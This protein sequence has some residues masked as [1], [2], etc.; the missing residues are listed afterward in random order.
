MFILVQVDRWAIYRGCRLLFRE[1]VRLRPPRQSNFAWAPTRALHLQRSLRFYRYLHSMDALIRPWHRHLK[2]TQH[3][4][5]MLN[6][7]LTGVMP[8]AAGDDCASCPPTLLVTPW[9]GG[10]GVGLVVEALAQELCGLGATCVVLKPVP[11]GWLPRLHRGSRG[12]LIVSICMRPISTTQSRARRGAAWMRGLMA[13]LIVV[14][15]A[16][17]FGLRVANFHYS[18]AENAL[19]HRICLKAGLRCVATFHGSDLVVSMAEPRAR[20]TAARVLNGCSAITAVSAALK[21]DVV[22]RFPEFAHFTYT[23][24]NAVPIDFHA[25]AKD[26]G[27]GVRDIDVL[28]VGYLAPHKGADVLI[29]AI[30]LV[31]E[32]V[33]PLRAVIVGG[34]PEAPKL[35]RLAK[36]LGV[37]R[38]VSFVGWK[39]REEL[40]L[41]YS[42]S[43]ILS[44][45][46]RREP[47]GLVVVEGQVWGAAVV[48]SAVGGIPEIIA[49]GKTGFL[50]P[51]D[52]PE[53][54]AATIIR[55]LQDEAVRTSIAEAA[56]CN[57]LEE[58]S[59]TAMALHY[60]EVYRRVDGATLGSLGSDAPLNQIS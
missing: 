33:S 22:A 21:R 4:P 49:D 47:F 14:C 34:G 15:L 51:P 23:V 17:R 35:E 11:D 25:Q 44:V 28:F 18:I 56:R 48:A 60:C 30:A 26:G 27:L 54:L 31:V 50:V 8:L 1:P 3:A 12:E 37:D 32:K 57:A 40:A 55:L 59:P 39:S 20:E 43:R 46:S 38:S 36:E 16:R 13:K 19:L 24:H 7:R 45:P 42:G 58:F 10:N 9:Y 2:R 53:V 5:T 29:R 41:L 52:D 6:S